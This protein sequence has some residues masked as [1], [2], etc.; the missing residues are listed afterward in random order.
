MKKSNLW[1]GIC[2]CLVGLGFLGAAVLTESRMESLLYGLTGASFGPGIMMILRYFYWNRPE[3]REA[4]RVQSELVQISQQDERNI[5]LRQ[6]AGWYTYV[7]GRYIVIGAMAVV[8]ILGVYG[9]VA[10]FRQIVLWL[11]GYLILQIGAYCLILN[12]LLKA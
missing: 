1:T 2:Y 8:S 12:R 10:Q 6:K 11:A 4:Y 9:V 7:L 5:Q 3:N